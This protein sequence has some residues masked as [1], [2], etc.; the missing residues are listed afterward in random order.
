MYGL[1]I[2]LCDTW[3]REPPAALWR[4]EYGRYMIEGTPG[5][6]YGAT[7]R[8]LVDVEDNMKLRRKMAHAAMDPD[9]YAVS[10]VNYPRLGCPNQ[11]Y[12]DHEPNGPA[13]QSM[14]V[15]DQIINPHARFP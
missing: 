11:L 14:F 10:L 2:G 4:P 15:P 5:L 12:P 13:C 6:P 7:F 3:Y 8:D 9:E 1:A